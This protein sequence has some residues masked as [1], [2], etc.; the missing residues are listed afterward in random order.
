MKNIWSVE[1]ILFSKRLDFQ[2]KSQSWKAE[3]NDKMTRE[4][5]SLANFEECSDS[6][7]E[8]QRS[9]AG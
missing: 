6:S 5:K 1:H 4:S 2:P 7:F 8:Q 9:A 3:R